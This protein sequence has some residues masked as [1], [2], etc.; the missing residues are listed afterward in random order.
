MNE[1]D[2]LDEL[3]EAR[4]QRQFQSRLRHTEYGS[5]DYYDMIDEE[6]EE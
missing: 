1:D 2:Y 3:Y 4:S 5:P 6:D